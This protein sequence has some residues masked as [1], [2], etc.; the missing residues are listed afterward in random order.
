MGEFAIFKFVFFHCT[1]GCVK[2]FPLPN[3]S[4]FRIIIRFRDNMPQ[5]KMVMSF[6]LVGQ[7]FSYVNENI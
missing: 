1:L 6:N 7:Y 2:S 4:L 3:F 5:K